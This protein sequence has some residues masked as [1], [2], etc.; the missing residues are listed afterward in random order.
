[1]GKP[2]NAR[3]FQAEMVFRDRALLSASPPLERS[4][5]CSFRSI[6]AKV[7]GTLVSKQCSTKLA[8]C[9]R[10]GG[11][12]HIPSTSPGPNK[13]TQGHLLLI[14]NFQVRPVLTR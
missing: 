11:V 5:E 12:W 10:Q 14:S 6:R 8:G 4:I 1:M 2:L 13:E 7:V 9:A 3:L